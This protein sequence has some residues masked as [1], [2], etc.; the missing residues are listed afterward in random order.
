MKQRN[1][2]LDILRCIAV[3]LVIGRHMWVCPPQISIILNK[4]TALICQVGWIGV[5]L[6]FVLSGFL[7]SGL[8]FK[9]YSQNGKISINR[10]YIRRGFKI[11]PS[12]LLLLGITA[13]FLLYQFSKFSAQIPD[14]SAFWKAFKDWLWPN[15]LFVQNY[16]DTPTFNE[17][18]VWSIKLTWS[19]AIEE[20]FY[21]ILPILLIGLLRIFKNFNAIPTLA[22]IFS[23]YCLFARLK[24]D[25]PFTTQNNLMPTHLRFDSLF[26]WCDAFLF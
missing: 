4:I 8:L 17:R 14:T 13:G 10:F 2:S 12:F 24:T 18:L 25:G 16:I 5:D 22:L 15:A 3:F 19:L 26:F 6:F 20:H 7:I 21:L 11:Y 1:S 9:D 23:L